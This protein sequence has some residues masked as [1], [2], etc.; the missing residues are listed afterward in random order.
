MLIR[1]IDVRAV[2]VDVVKLHSIELLHFTFEL[3]LA[4]S[5]CFVLKSLTIVAKQIH[6]GCSQVYL[7]EPRFQIVISFVVDFRLYVVNIPASI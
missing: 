2:T 7:L 5:R 3:H 4:E 1:Y 6:V